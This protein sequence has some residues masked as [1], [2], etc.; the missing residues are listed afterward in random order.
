LA[1]DSKFEHLVDQQIS[2]SA[3]IQSRALESGQYYARVRSFVKNI[4]TEWSETNMFSLNLTRMKLPPPPAPILLTENISFKPVA[5]QG[6]NPAS[7]AQP[8]MQWQSL[9]PAKKFKLQISRRSDFKTAAEVDTQ[10]PFYIWSKYRP[11]QYYFRVY[12]LGENNIW[13]NP[14]NAGT[15]NVQLDQPVIDPLAEVV[16]KDHSFNATPPEKSVQ[17]QWTEI[18]FAE[19]YKVE[20]KNL[21]SKISKSQTFEV[22][23]NRASFKVRNPSSYQIQVVPLDEKN[24]PLTLP[25]A[26]ADF[27]YTFRS[28]LETPKILFPQNQFTLFLQK[29]NSV[30]LKI[31]W[32]NVKRAQAYKLEV[33]EFENFQTTLLQETVSGTHFLMQ[34]KLPY[35]KLYWRVK[36]KAEFINDD[37]D[38]T[39]KQAF[40]LYQKKNDIF[41]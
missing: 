22:S 21:Q 39:D 41:E 31:R 4:N 16:V 27:K 26:P 6:R 20:I 17:I 29:D 9:V 5:A 38:W 25:S 11:G 12:L 18:P 1:T 28:L 2:K 15:L 8:Q 40:T 34:K 32:Q 35:K 23:Q 3:K 14:S 36:A 24:K 7:L 13:S 10:D 30:D 33:S 37:S 19:K